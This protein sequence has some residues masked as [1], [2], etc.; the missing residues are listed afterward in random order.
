MRNR[1]GAN[2]NAGG[3]KA[4]GGAASGKNDA[5][6]ATTRRSAALAKKASELSTRIERM[7]GLRAQHAKGVSTGG[8]KDAEP[9]TT[10]T[11][12][13]Q[14]P[15]VATH[16]NFVDVEAEAGSGDSDDDE[17][18][19]SQEEVTEVIELDADDDDEASEEERDDD[20]PEDESD[21][22]PTLSRLRRKPGIV[23]EAGSGDSEDDEDD[24]LNADDDDEAAEEERDDDAPEDESDAAPTHSRLRRKPAIAV[25]DDDDDEASEE[26]SVASR[27]KQ[28]PVQSSDDDDD[29]GN[30]GPEDA[31]EHSD[32]VKEINAYYAH[33]QERWQRPNAS[34]EPDASEDDDEASDEAP[35]D[36]AVE[37]WRPE[38]QPKQR[39]TA[40]KAS[41]TRAPLV[42][43]DASPAEEEPPL[44]KRRT[45]LS[46]PTKAP[47]AARGA[48]T[49]IAGTRPMIKVFLLSGSGSAK[50]HRHW[51]MFV[52]NSPS[53]FSLCEILTLYT[54]KTQCKNGRTP[55]WAQ[56]PNG[57]V[58]IEGAGQRKD[59][60]KFGDS[61]EISPTATVTP[62]V[63]DDTEKEAFATKF[64]NPLW[65]DAKE[66]FA[67]FARVEEVTKS[68]GV[69]DNSPTAFFVINNGNLS[70]NAKT[71]LKDPEHV[72]TVKKGGYILAIGS[73]YAHPNGEKSFTIKALQFFPSMAAV[74][75]KMP[76]TWARYASYKLMEHQDITTPEK[77]FYEIHKELRTG[78]LGPKMSWCKDTTV[79]VVATS[80]ILTQHACNS[81]SK[82]MT[83]DGETAT[84]AEHGD[85]PYPKIVSR[86]TLR[87][88]IAVD[89]NK[90][91]PVDAD[92]QITAQV[93]KDNEKALLGME[94]E[95]IPEN[96]DV[97]GILDSLVGVKYNVTIGVSSTRCVI[98]K[99]LKI[100]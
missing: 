70:F 69:N 27:P 63:L 76:D 51:A 60:E 16:L 6:Q 32:G 79:E 68:S 28:K 47:L 71:F 93:G 46:S 48:T 58:V 86:P 42:E 5:K 43:G 9:A 45:A 88:K 49:K 66:K 12:A 64:A 33:L 36:D 1:G 4:K 95:E 20:A 29:D 19:D 30:P 40:A 97:D 90:S 15:P 59:S 22:A 3:K 23:A 13:L 24:D 14:A 35:P 31:D 65:V 99:L 83:I 8:N 73:M 41:T 91:S 74:K 34:A 92:L 96:A 87:L 55:D 21:A 82:I 25:D 94:A 11:R 61:M 17:D 75:E 89:E 7:E 39:L 77:T 85:D 98:T 38:S 57:P 56:A 84:C 18:D 72:A 100:E 53:G 52:R 50:Q 26:E 62:F 54:W 67:V 78:L 10:R 81:C 2:K 80:N 37:E 44:K